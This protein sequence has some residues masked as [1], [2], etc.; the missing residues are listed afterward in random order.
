[1]KNRM[2]TIHEAVNVRS[3]NWL[4]WL[5]CGLVIF[6]GLDGILT[7]VWV[8][9]SSAVEANPLMAYLIDLHPVIFISMKNV[10]VSLGAVLLW[11]LRSHSL[12]SAGI[13]L[14][15]SMYCSV[16]VIQMRGFIG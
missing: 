3:K 16:M 10:L 4:T 11:R 2:W 13:V 1:M 7:L 9:R 5:L 15:F 8:Y 12:A 6:N 14:A